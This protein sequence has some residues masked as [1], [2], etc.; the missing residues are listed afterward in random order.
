MMTHIQR[1]ENSS[2][3]LLTLTRKRQH[4]TPVF[5]SLT[6]IPVIFRSKYSILVYA[7]KPPNGTALRYLEELVLPYQLTRSLRSDSESLITV[8]KMQGVTY[9]NRCFGKAAVTLWN[10]LPL[11]IRKCNTLSGFNQ[12]FSYSIYVIKTS[13]KYF[14]YKFVCILMTN[15][16]TFYNIREA[17]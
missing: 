3:R 13:S 6:W 14:L 8:P 10:N 17:P 9:G 16:F 11:T 4:I 15:C 7:Y 12:S 1:V 5:N 2:A